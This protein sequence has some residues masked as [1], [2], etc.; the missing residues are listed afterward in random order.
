MY[1][2]WNDIQYH[3]FSLVCWIR[4][5]SSFPLLFFSFSCPFVNLLSFILHCSKVEVPVNNISF[6]VCIL[7]VQSLQT[8]VDTRTLIYT[9]SMRV[10]NYIYDTNNSIYLY[11]VTDVATISVHLFLSL[12]VPLSL[13]LYLFIYCCSCKTS[14]IVTGLMDVNCAVWLLL[15]NNFRIEILVAF[16]LSSLIK[17]LKCFSNT[18]S[19]FLIN[20]WKLGI[21]CVVIVDLFIS[22][23]Y[24]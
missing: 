21:I 10:H 23:F 9:M 13:S 15:R 8:Y 17:P 12:S 5:I 7:F 6:Y 22:N 1:F 11:V 14:V 20:V 3:G 18:F 16:D 19:T 24:H 2:H 4:M